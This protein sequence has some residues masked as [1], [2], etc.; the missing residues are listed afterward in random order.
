MKK[1]DFLPDGVLKFCGYN[2]CLTIEQGTYAQ[3][4]IQQI[5]RG[6]MPG[7]KLWMKPQ[8]LFPDSRFDKTK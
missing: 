6:P 4:M 2:S 5:Y 1:Q 8:C 7:E 3:K